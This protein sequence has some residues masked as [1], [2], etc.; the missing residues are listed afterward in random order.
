MLLFSLP[1]LQIGRPND[2]KSDKTLGVYSNGY[3]TARRII[4]VTFCDVPTLPLAILQLIP[5]GIVYIDD[6]GSNIIH[7]SEWICLLSGQLSHVRV[8]RND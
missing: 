3:N 2:T 7:N 4:Y 6:R 1:G 8:N 5:S